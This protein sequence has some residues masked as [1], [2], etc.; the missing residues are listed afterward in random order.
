MITSIGGLGFE[1][2]LV[3][4]VPYSG[5]TMLMALGKIR[6]KAVVV[7][8]KIEIIPMMPIGATID[9]RYADGYTG[10]KMLKPLVDYLENPV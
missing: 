3:P 5:C 7:N 6:E 9:H 8:G 4:L 2:A 10:K 1:H